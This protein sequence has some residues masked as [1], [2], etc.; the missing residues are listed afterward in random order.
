MALV[1]HVM[2]HYAYALK[3]STLEYETDVTIPAVSG[4]RPAKPARDAR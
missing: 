1:Q 3:I 2:R 4:Y